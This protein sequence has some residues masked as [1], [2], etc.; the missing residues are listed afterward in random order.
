MST[1]LSAREKTK[2]YWKMPALNW[3][4]RDFFILSPENT[5]WCNISTFSPEFCTR[6]CTLKDTDSTTLP[7]RSRKTAA[8]V[9]K[10]YSCNSISVL[11]FGRQNSSLA[12]F[13]K[14][15]SLWGHSVSSW[16]ARAPNKQKAVQSRTNR[17]GK[18]WR[19]SILY[20]VQFFLIVPVI[21]LGQKEIVK[22]FQA[23]FSFHFTWYIL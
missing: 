11:G 19:Y 5:T 13:H 3:I 12:E 7:E 8:K 22:H 9:S 18:M 14:K 16:P 23:V 17:K 15:K 20:E 21:K 4:V 2:F 10:I 1:K 6:F